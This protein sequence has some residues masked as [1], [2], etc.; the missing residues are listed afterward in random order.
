MELSQIKR[1]RRSAMVART[2]GLEKTG[3][4]SSCF[5]QLDTKEWYISERIYPR[6]K[7]RDNQKRNE[8]RR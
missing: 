2:V 4:K 3:R 5:L 6:G 7:H 1:A 8:K